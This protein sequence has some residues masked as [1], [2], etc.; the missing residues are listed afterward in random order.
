MGG[1]KSGI[2]KQAEKQVKKQQKKET[3]MKKPIIITVVV[4][5]VTVAAFGATFFLGMSYE[6]GI[7]NR[8]TNEA[9]ALT[10]TVTS[11]K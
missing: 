7:N 5:L 9:K 1:F 4:T 3:N 2:T 6:H 8:V 10:A 11:K